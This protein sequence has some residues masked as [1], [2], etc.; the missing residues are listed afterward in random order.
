MVLRFPCLCFRESR[1]NES[2]DDVFNH[3]LI[4]A[5]SQQQGDK[6]RSGALPPAAAAGEDTAPRIITSSSNPADQTLGFDVKPA[7]NNRT[8]DDSSSGVGQTERSSDDSTNTDV[9][10]ME[11]EELSESGGGGDAGEVAAPEDVEISVEEARAES[12]SA[13]L[14]AGDTDSQSSAS[15]DAP[16]SDTPPSPCLSAEEATHSRPATQYSSDSDQGAAE[17]TGDNTNTTSDVESA[18]VQDSDANSGASDNASTS[19]EHFSGDSASSQEGDVETRI[20]PTCTESPNV[21]EQATRPDSLP[22]EEF[23]QFAYWR[24]PLPDIDIDADLSP[25]SQRLQREEAA[26]RRAGEARAAAGDAAQATATAGSDA[27]T[28]KKLDSAAEGTNDP[29]L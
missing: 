24:D 14:R 25:N 10:A 9:V 23:T 6:S 12:H 21:T 28:D 26:A 17:T 16:K 15:P 22:V 4:E 20:P 1:A 18:N 27:E 2:I 11:T 7:E 3:S 8:G 13:K 5:D 29:K 19:A